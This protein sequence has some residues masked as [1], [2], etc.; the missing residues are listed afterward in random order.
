MRKNVFRPEAI[1]DLKSISA[2]LY[3]VSKNKKAGKKTMEKIIKKINRLAD[4]PELG[5]DISAITDE[6][7]GYRFLV[8]GRYIVFY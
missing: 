2:H 1:N 7:Q 4:F 8:I 6:I 5:M 3:E